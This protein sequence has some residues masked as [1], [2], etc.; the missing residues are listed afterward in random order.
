MLPSP[1]DFFAKNRLLFLVVLSGFLLIGLGIFFAKAGDNL[2][3]T[4]VEVLN[5]TTEAQEAVSEVVVE[6][7]GGV[8]KPGVYSFKEGSRVEDL[9][10]VSG[11]LSAGADR[12]WVSQNLNRAA[13]LSDGQKVFIPAVGKTNQG[14]APAALNAAGGVVVSNL[15]NINTSDLKTL[16][17]LPG[18]GPVYGQNIIEHRPYSSGEELLSKGVLKKSV[19]EKIKD[20]ITVY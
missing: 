1:A 14:L 12:T 5:S 20:K 6:I 18:I 13:R 16:D 9:L 11:G 3:G 10:V 15:I 8:E 7:S 2:S 17:T 4:K 19:Y